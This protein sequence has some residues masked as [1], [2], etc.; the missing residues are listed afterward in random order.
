MVDADRMMKCGFSEYTISRFNRRSFNRTKFVQA[1]DTSFKRD[2]KKKLEQFINTF[3]GKY[4]DDWYDMCY[5]DTMSHSNLSFT[6]YLYHEKE[7]AKSVCIFLVHLNFIEAENNENYS[8]Y[9][10]KMVESVKETL[11]VD[12]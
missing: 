8:A 3:V 9:I 2:L 1:I 5:V 12:N 10:D 4:G 6:F 11:R 7:K